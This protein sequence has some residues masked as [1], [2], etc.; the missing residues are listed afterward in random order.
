MKSKNLP[1][2]SEVDLSKR[3]LLIFLAVVSIAVA[4]IPL[5]HRFLSQ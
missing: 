2:K 4:A 3:L 1:K 5:I